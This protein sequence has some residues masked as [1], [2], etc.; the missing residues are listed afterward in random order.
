[1]PRMEDTKVTT[2]RLPGRQATE[3]EAIARVENIP[4]SEAIR[5]A[6]A[7]LIERRRGDEEF[8]T[9]LR[10]RIEEDREI[11]EELSRS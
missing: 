5:E 3:L 7:E 9:R 1:M 11:L 10:R 4:V 8:M 6:V 2:V